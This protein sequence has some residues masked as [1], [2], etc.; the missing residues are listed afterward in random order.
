MIQ[1][2]RGDIFLVGGGDSRVEPISMI[3]AVLFA[4]LSHRNDRPA[5]ACR[6]FDRARDGGVLS[7]GAGVLVLE[8]L[9]HARRR[10]APIVAEL[11]G[12]AGAFDARRDGSGLARACRQALTEAGQNPDDLDHLNAHGASTV[13]GDAWEAQGLRQLQ[14]TDVRVFA[15]RS[16]FGNLGVA[17]GLAELSASLLALQRGVLPGTLNYQHPDPT[18]PVAISREP[19]PVVR[20]HV[21]KVSCTEMG[22]CGA[23]VCRSW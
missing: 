8:E 14:E 9:E 2:D 17:A 7:E 1:H 21:L 3:R 20:E 6:P 10:Q 5:E 15:P 23:V 12:F 16:Y 4:E 22:Q 18:C 11:L 13:A 19:T